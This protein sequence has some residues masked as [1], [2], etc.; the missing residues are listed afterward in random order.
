[1]VWIKSVSHTSIIGENKIFS[2]KYLLFPRLINII[3]T[4]AVNK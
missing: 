2:Q 4:A 1:M 3:T